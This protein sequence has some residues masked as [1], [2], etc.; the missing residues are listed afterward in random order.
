MAPTVFVSLLLVAA[1]RAGALYL[2]HLHVDIAVG[3]RRTSTAWWRPATYLTSGVSL[4]SFLVILWGLS[5]PAEIPI[6]KWGNSTYTCVSGLDSIFLRRLGTWLTVKI[7]RP[8]VRLNVARQ[9]FEADFRFSL[10]RFR[11]NAESVALYGGEPV[12]LRVLN[13]RFRSV[14]ENFRHIMKRQRRL[15]CST[16]KLHPSGGH[17][18]P[19]GRFTTLLREADRVGR[20]DAGGQRVL[21]RAELALLYH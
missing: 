15:T 21:L 19:G 20:T 11:E 4:V 8:L 12:E 2:N 14:F 13:E 3:L 7:G 9:R 18:P 10:V 5:G 16:L 17:L 6:G 1:C